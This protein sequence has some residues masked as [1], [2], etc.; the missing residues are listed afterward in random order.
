MP[1]GRLLGRGAG[2][3]VRGV[4]CG[5]L[6]WVLAAS[7]L[8]VVAGPVDDA[9]AQTPAV[10]VV[11]VPHDWALIPDGVEVGDEF[12][13]VFV[14][15]QRRNARSSNIADY[16]SFVRTSAAGSS[17][18][19]ALR[20]YSQHFK[21]LGS[22][23]SVHARDH[24]GMHPDNGDHQDVPVYWVDGP[25]AA[26]G[27]FAVFSSTRFG[28]HGIGWEADGRYA[29]GAVVPS[30]GTSRRVW[31]GSRENGAGRG[32][33][34]VFG[35]IGVGWGLAG[36]T[37]DHI[38]SGTSVVA[39]GTSYSLYGVSAVFRAVAGSLVSNLGQSD[40][41]FLGL[42]PSDRAQAFS[43]GS[44]ESGYSLGGVDV[45]FTALSDNQVF[46]SKV[47][48]AVWSDSGGAPGALVATLVNPAYQADDC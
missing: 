2:S 5:L 6:V 18:H 35:Q 22:T 30:S 16:D 27:N 25:R 14:T 28:E 44:N 9:A 15:Q 33:T 43:T 45:E 42:A 10:E 29:S 12:R 11:D 41:G 8:A 32:A 47:T 13:L 34:G 37:P 20:A 21:A 46:A 38:H 7:V 39:A 19:A 17:A 3:S 40:G 24:L 26:A 31:T 48:A 23:S 4:V 1:R 36:R